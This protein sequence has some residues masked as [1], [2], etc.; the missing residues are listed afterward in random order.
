MCS[1]CTIEKRF[2]LGHFYG[3]KPLSTEDST[4]TVDSKACETPPLL[5]L[6][7][8]GWRKVEA[9]REERE[10][11]STQKRERGGGVATDSSKE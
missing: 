8:G 1:T 5:R 6:P 2:C 11:P 4:G 3:N 9:E 10:P 7:V